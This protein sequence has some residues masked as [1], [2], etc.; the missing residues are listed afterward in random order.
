M[1]VLYGN[2][3]HQKKN[4]SLLSRSATFDLKIARGGKLLHLFT[5]K[6]KIRSALRLP[7]QKVLQLLQPTC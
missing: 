5:Y 3:L 1:Y 7:H 2:L 4:Q 6:K